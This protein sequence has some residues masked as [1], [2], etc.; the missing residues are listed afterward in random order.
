MT[1]FKILVI[2]DEELARQKI[3]RFLDNTSVKLPGDLLI[4]EAQ[5]GLIG[6]EKISS[7]CPDLVFLDVQMPGLSGIEL[8]QQIEARA[9][10]IIFAT[11]HEE[12]ALKAFEENACDYLLK[13]FDQERFNC[14][15]KKV[16]KL[17]SQEKVFLGI[18]DS[19]RSRGHHLG[20]ITY[21]VGEKIKFIQTS[22]VIYF[23]SRDHYTYAHTI[24]GE[25]LID[26]SLTYLEEKLDT[27]NFLRI[28]RHVIVGLA[29]ITAFKKGEPFLI[30]LRNGIELP[31]SRNNR[32]TL[33]AKIFP[34]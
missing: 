12:F 18:E 25:K 23:E 2:D 16:L 15:L 29:N 32:K 8:L 9:F 5:N 27:Q 11:A 13:P 34:Y 14:A 21:K 26:L 1:K 28:H 19:Y 17:H 30:Q 4:N 3:L 6:L 10:K 20:K 7:F 24:E 33:L 22:E 31:V